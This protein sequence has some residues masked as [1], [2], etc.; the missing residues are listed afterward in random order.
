MSR[1]HWWC[2][3]TLTISTSTAVTKKKKH[4]Q[5]CALGDGGR[6]ASDAFDGNP[7]GVHV[8]KDDSRGPRQNVVCSRPTLVLRITKR[9]G[10]AGFRSQRDTQGNK[11]DFM[12]MKES[13]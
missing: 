1:L 13:C 7:R 3:S 12:S 5:V 8:D 9:D 10:H 2:A 6:S 4:V 11:A